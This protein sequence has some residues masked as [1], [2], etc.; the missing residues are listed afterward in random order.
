MQKPYKSIRVFKNPVL[1]SLTHVHPLVP[2][3]LW[4]PITAWMLW[5][6]FSVHQLSPLE[7]GSLGALGFLIWTF[8]EY[9][10]HRF[11]FHYEAE[12]AIGQKIHFLIHGLHHSD[13]IDPTRLVMPPAGSLILAVVLFGF[14]RLL[15][16]PALVEPFFAF[17][18]IGYLCYDYIHYA[19]HHFKP[20]TRF[21][22][23]LKH[24]HMLHH[25]A[26]PNARWGV[27]S[28]LWDYVFGTLEDINNKEQPV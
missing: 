3:V 17:Y 10:L 5:R 4:A 19:V 27:S 6:S 2:L 24:H 16:G 18:V 23:M 7:V 1:E 9:I 25:Y 8:S 28:P 20:R 14:F 13:P 11:A 26:T 12:S 21:G 15:L 22:K